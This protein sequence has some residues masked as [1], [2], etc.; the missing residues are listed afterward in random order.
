M[1]FDVQHI[2]GPD[3]PI[4]RRLSNQYELRP[5]QLH[6][7][8]QIDQTLQH[9]SN[10]IAEAGTG[11][12]KSFAYLLPAV[13]RIVEDNERVIISTQTISLQ[14]QLIEKD[15]PLLRAVLGA[16]FSAVLVKGRGNYV[17]LRRLRQSSKRQAQL[18]HTEPELRSLHTVEDWA[19]ETTDGSLA[20]LPVL[21]RQNI[22]AKVQSDSSNCMGRKCDTYN[23]CFYQAARRRME[24]GDLLI[25][26]HALFFADLAMRAS[27]LGFLPPY[28]HVILDEAH[29]IEDIVSDHF[30]VTI[31][32]TAVNHLLG[33]L[34]H[35]RHRKGFLTSISLKDTS[36][37]NL[38]EKAI[39]Q[40]HQ[41][42]IASECFFDDLTEWQQ[43]KGRKNGRVNEPNIVKNHLHNV[44][45]DLIIILRSLIPKVKREADQFELNGYI[46]RAQV[47]NSAITT[48]LQHQLNDA[49]YWMEVSTGR[50]Q[51]VKLACAPIDVAP[52]LREH[53]FNKTNCDN[54][55]VGIVLTSATLATG[56]QQQSIPSEGSLNYEP[57]DEE[58]GDPQKDPTPTQAKHP[59]TAFKHLA[60]RLGCEEAE[61]IQLGSP[62]DYESAVRLIIEQDMPEPNSDQYNE[63]LGPRILNHIRATAGG[64]FVLFTNYGVL[65]KMA[66]WLTPH[67]KD[68]ALTLLVQGRDGPRSILL[69]R[70]KHDGSAVLLGTDS[71]WQGVDVRGDALRNVIITRLPFA[72]PD[73]PLTEAR[74][75]RIRNRGGSPFMDYQLPEAIIK[76]KQGFGRL[77]RSH[78][79]TGRVVVLDKRISSKPYGKKFVDALPPIHIERVKNF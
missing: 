12:G 50:F 34:F 65:N 48:W 66:D 64:T 14:E 68:L 18:F 23:K 70:F 67:V 29:T 1:S 42:Y 43:R 20:S 69:Q 46:D 77:I 3:G 10:L 53:L 28:D 5:Q 30:G 56:N 8:A 19:Y 33:S 55:P 52:L 74:I 54:S 72:V 47:C 63:Q 51:R 35:T 62:F 76:F 25:V 78:A 22:W 57:I 4:A 49:V 75:E 17:S 59:N 24:N 41:T 11:V 45:K 38:V 58:L 6:M 9:G 71:F 40:V 39:D 27:G 79:D 21:E 15:I 44:L 32:D 37:I 36:E 26:N 31:A 7:A 73:L 61:T 16:E 13:K 2:L 60:S